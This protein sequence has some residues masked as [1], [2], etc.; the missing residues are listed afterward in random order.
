MVRAAR[1]QDLGNHDPR[2]PPAFVL[3][4]SAAAFTLAAFRRHDMALPVNLQNAVPKR[5]AEFLMGR[6]AARQAIQRLGVAAS[7]PAI[8]ASREPRW[9]P[10]VTGSITHTRDMAAAIALPSSL[11]NGV[12]I[13]IETVIDAGTRDALQHV[14][15][16]PRERDVLESRRDQL[17]ADVLLTIAFSAKESFFKATFASVGRYF[18]FNAARVSHLDARSSQLTLTLEET[19]CPSLPKGRDFAIGFRLLSEI[20]VLTSFIW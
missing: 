14:V 4:F 18:D 3:E 15:I 7:T 20:T 13:D 9:Q 8:G 1:W 10:G 19:L 12:G 6:L 17:S 16:T 2:L 11:A 5:Q